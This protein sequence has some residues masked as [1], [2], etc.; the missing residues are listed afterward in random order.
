M[1]GKIITVIASLL[2]A[3]SVSC[4]KPSADTGTPEPSVE[5]SVKP[6]M[7]SGNV[8]QSVLDLPTHDLLDY[9]VRDNWHTM[10]MGLKSLPYVI[11]FTGD[12]DYE[13]MIMQSNLPDVP[14]KYA[15][16][17]ELPDYEFSV[18]CAESEV[19]DDLLRRREIIDIVYAAVTDSPEK[20]P[21]L[22]S[23]YAALNIDITSYVES[24][25]TGISEY[26]RNNNFRPD[27]M[28]SGFALPFDK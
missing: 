23:D 25:S 6:E 18:L 12:D 3:F 17:I 7:T 27:T 20:Y 15:V 28:L 22:I 21:K 1:I 24:F 16:E 14:E 13:E 8:P 10:S 5:P 26:T 11:H 9:F 4:A 2:L 19:F